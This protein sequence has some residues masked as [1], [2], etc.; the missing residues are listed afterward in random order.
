MG[1]KLPELFHAAELEQV[2]CG[3]YDGRWEKTLSREDIE[4]EWLM[5]EDDLKSILSNA[6]LNELR[7]HEQKA[8]TKGSRLIYV[9]TFYA[10][11][12]IP[13]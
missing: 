3:V 11:G 12:R 7:K 6:E 10:W 8:I 9:P 13:G 1:R 5:L 4:S 2:H